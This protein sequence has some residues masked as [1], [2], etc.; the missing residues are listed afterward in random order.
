MAGELQEKL[1]TRTTACTTQI[2]VICL[3]RMLCEASFSALRPALIF[4][5]K[6]R[7]EQRSCF[8][9]TPVA[10]KLSQPTTEGS[11]KRA[12]R[13]PGAEQGACVG[14]GPRLDTFLK[15]SLQA[16]ADG[17]SRYPQG[18][19]MSFVEGQLNQP[20]LCLYCRS[21]SM[22]ATWRLPKLRRASNWL[23][24]VFCSLLFESSIQKCSAS[25]ALLATGFQFSVG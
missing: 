10:S 22:K 9:S 6:L 15:H 7:S 21:G 5:E 8:T 2:E 17:P 12:L 18:A 14:E 3:P 20:S 13:Q 16:S 25:D 4:L 24:S 11:S 19:R 23:K 1:A